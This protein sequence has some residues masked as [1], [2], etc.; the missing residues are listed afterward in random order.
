MDQKAEVMAR[1]SNYGK[2]AP[3]RPESDLKRKKPF[4]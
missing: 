2:I 3:R 1:E 4:L